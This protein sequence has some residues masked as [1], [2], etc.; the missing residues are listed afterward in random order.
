MCQRSTEVSVHWQ[1]N[2]DFSG[3]QRIV[4]AGKTILLADFDAEAAG[5]LLGIEQN[6]RGAT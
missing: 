4:F 2:G 5:G 3:N 1:T 6:H